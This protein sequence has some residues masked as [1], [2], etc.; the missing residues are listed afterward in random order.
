MSKL[1]QSLIMKD[2]VI[3]QLE[4]VSRRAEN[5]EVRRLK[6]DLRTSRMEIESQLDAS[7]YQKNELNHLNQKL[8]SSKNE[9]SKLQAELSR[10]QE[11]VKFLEDNDL[12]Q[13]MLE[14]SKV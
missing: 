2:E 3:R 5:I 12:K 9:I 4:D 6:E 7:Q 8:E 14:N 10:K 11:E 1:E 13:L